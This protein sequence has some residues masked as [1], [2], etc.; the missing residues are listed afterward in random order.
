MESENRA[1]GHLT[2]RQSEKE[3][4]SESCIKQIRCKVA[5]LSEHRSVLTCHRL[6]DRVVFRSWYRQYLLFSYEKVR[7]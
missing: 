5:N 1:A 2:I 7:G 3:R 4:E 6:R